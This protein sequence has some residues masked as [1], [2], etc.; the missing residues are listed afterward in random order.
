MIMLHTLGQ[1]RWRI[2][3]M[4]IALLCDWLHVLHFVIAST[5]VYRSHDQ[6]GKEE[7]YFLAIEAK[8]KKTVPFYKKP[9]KIG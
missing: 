1:Q 4:N 7:E 3:T 5:L 6:S 2:F 8:K 9:Q